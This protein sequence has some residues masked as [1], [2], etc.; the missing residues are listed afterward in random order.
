MRASP[1]RRREGS[2][3]GSVAFLA[4]GVAC[5]M[6]CAH[7]AAAGE[8]SARDTRLARWIAAHPQWLWGEHRLQPSEVQRLWAA[9]SVMGAALVALEF[10]VKPPRDARWDRT[11][12]F[13]DE[14]RG[15]LKGESRSARRAASIASEVFYGGLLAGLLVDDVWL[16]REYP[17]LK[18]YMLDGSWIITTALVTRG[19]KLAAGRERPFVDPCRTDSDYVDDCD[20]GRSGNASFFS[21]HASTSATVAGLICSHHLHRA[22]TGIY[23]WITCG[24][25]AAASAATGVFRIT[26]EQHHATDV[27]AGWA[28]GVLFGYVLPSRFDYGLRT[29]NLVSNLLAVEPVATPQFLGVRLQYSF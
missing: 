22:R 17:V 2:R 16:R 28:T 1:P 7:P 5:I 13:D 21:G 8:P 11:N 10:A 20:D 29:E 25:A 19:A 18:R 3:V 15:A 9:Y 14:I 26:A 4:A 23:D 24:G 12:E 6:A 27:L